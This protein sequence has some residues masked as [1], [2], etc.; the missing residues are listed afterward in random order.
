MARAGRIDSGR[1]LDVSNS[2]MDTI[3]APTM[4]RLS[5]VADAAEAAGFV[6]VGAL[7]EEETDD[8]RT[9]RVF[10]IDAR[11][12]LIES[13]SDDEGGRLISGVDAFVRVPEISGHTLRGMLADEAGRARRDLPGAPL[14]GIGGVRNASMLR[15][16]EPEDPAGP[17]RPLR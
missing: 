9:V 5:A 17:A 1:G 2:L 3:D 14:A 16:L 8:G 10:S 12:R 15:A 11:D 13:V 4:E 7:V 6:R